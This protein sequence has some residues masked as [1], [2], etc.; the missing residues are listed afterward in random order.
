MARL[1]ARG[2]GKIGCI[3][4]LTVFA[5]AALIAYKMIPVKIASSQ[6]YDYMEDEA[7]FSAGNSPELLKKKIYEKARE[8]DLPIKE[9][10]ITVEKAGDNIK[11]RAVYDVPVEFPGYTYVWHFDHQLNRPIYIF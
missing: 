10:Q 8:L 3:L 1:Q 6:F 11:M 2:E 4:W 7:K 9:E 5:V